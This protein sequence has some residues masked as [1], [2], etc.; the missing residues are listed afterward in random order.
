MSSFQKIAE[1]IPGFGQHENP[2]KGFAERQGLE[3]ITGRP[4]QI[5]DIVLLPSSPCVMD[6]E[7]PGGTDRENYVA[8]AALK[9]EIDKNWLMEGEGGLAYLVVSPYEIQSFADS[10]KIL[11]RK[12][13]KLDERLKAD[14]EITHADEL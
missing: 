10:L 1:Q 4:M 14:P 6:F 3:V 9:I 8:M 12:A 7:E 5:A 11:A 2:I 13:H